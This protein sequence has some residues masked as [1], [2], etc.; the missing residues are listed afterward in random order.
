[1]HEG[2]RQVNMS[3]VL[4]ME[5]RRLTGPVPLLL[6]NLAAQL[7]PYVPIQISQSYNP[8]S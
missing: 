4:L 1:M 6:P 5:R 3:G 2:W 7:R 8:S